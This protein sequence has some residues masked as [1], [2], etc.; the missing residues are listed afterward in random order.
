MS[1]TRWKPSLAE[2]L[3]FQCAFLRNQGLNDAVFT[4]RSL[5]QKCHR[6]K[7]PL[8]LAFVDLRK[9]YDSIPRGALW[10][11]LSSYGVLPAIVRLLADLHTG[12]QAAVKLAADKGRW[13]GMDRGVRQC[14][15][16]APLLFITFFDCVV[17]LALSQLPADCGVGLSCDR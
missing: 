6:H 5:L 16:I 10:H 17:R 12:T 14:R 9:A 1:V 8:F 11:V 7:Q 2:L 4:L 3:E 13:F 15:V